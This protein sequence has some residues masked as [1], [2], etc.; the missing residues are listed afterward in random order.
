[1]KTNFGLFRILTLVI[2]T[3]SLLPSCKKSETPTKDIVGTWTSGTI[4]YT[5]MVGNEPLNQ[6]LLNDSGLSTVEAQTYAAIFDQAT[7]HALAGTIEVKKD[8]TYTS[9]L[10]GSSDSGTWSMSSDGKTLT[11]DSNSQAPVTLNVVELTSNKLHVTFV[12]TD[13]SDLNGDG[14]DEAITINADIIF[15]K[16]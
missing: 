9:T 16:A 1:M 6:W 4:T 12:E 15:N 13:N 8:G 5:A 14:T 11:V 7:Q 3:G 10:G 2:L